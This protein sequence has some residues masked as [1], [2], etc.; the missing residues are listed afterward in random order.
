M[1]NLASPSSLKS[2][3]NKHYIN[4]YYAGKILPH[5]SMQFD[6]DVHIGDTDRNQDITNIREQMNLS[7][8]KAFK[9]TNC[10]RVN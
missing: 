6:G 4:F 7:Q 10:M 1:K 3:E 8:L 9:T 2:E 5:L